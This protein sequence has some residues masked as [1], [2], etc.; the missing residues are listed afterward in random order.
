[1]GWLQTPRGLCGMP[2]TLARVTNVSPVCYAS[3]AGSRNR[4]LRLW[5]RLTP[6]GK[7]D[8]VYLFW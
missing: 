4:L 1:V 8:S 5:P 3:V 6:K 7:S 2:P